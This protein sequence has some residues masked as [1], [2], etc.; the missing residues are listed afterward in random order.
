MLHYC[1]DAAVSEF[2]NSVLAWS[3]VIQFSNRNKEGKPKKFSAKN[4]GK[5]VSGDE[6]AIF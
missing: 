6:K 3:M 2:A 5:G 1:T 4:V